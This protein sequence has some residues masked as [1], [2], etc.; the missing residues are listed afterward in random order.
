MTGKSNAVNTL[1]PSN[2]YYPIL[3]KILNSIS[4]ATVTANNI[5]KYY[6]IRPKI[7]CHQLITNKQTL[8]YDTN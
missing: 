4:M 6:P 8:S 5:Y 2:E 1:M 7:P 3:T